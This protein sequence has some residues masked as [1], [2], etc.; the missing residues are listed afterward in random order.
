ML[1]LSHGEMIELAGSSEIVVML[2][3]HEKSFECDSGR[4][5]R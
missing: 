4:W 3:N 2:K 1:L 5:C